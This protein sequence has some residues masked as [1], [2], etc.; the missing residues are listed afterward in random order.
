MS[1]GALLIGIAILLLAGVALAD[2]WA[3]RRSRL[4]TEGQTGAGAA[5]QAGDGKATL[6][7]LRDLDFD[8]QTGQVTNSDYKATRSKLLAEAA[9]SL[10][11]ESEERQAAEVQIE[12][13]VLRHRKYSGTQRT[14]PECGSRVEGAHHFCSHCGTSLPETCESCGST[15]KDQD[16]FCPACGVPTDDRIGEIS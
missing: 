12:R 13:A 4:E 10:V 3:R 9:S 5:P 7:A 8:Y 16:S 2:P 14:C 11:A 15:I 1:I 6:Y